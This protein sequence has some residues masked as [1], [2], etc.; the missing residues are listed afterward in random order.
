MAVR[1]TTVADFAAQVGGN[2]PVPAG[3]SIASVSAS[4]ALALLAKVLD[5]A[6]K[7]KDFQ[8]DRARI[9]ALIDSC[10]SESKGFTELADLDVLA[11]NEFLEC[12]RSS[13]GDGKHEAMCKCIEVPMQGARAVI[14]GLNLCVEGVEVVRGLTAADLGIA[15]AMLHGAIRSML[16]SV[17]FNLLHL[18]SATPIFDKLK[19]ERRELELEAA[20]RDDVITTAVRAL[21]L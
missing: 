19:T 4:L 8:G 7:R 21:L 1:D 14:R 9:Q 2:Q 3:V 15:A 6:T 5:I 11:F 16:I 10:R 12:V 13:K 18:D 20:R 17:D